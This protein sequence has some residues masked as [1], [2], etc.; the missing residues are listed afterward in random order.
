MA[1]HGVGLSL[2]GIKKTYGQAVALEHI[3]LTVAPGE[4]MTF[5][6]PSGSGK[7]TTL[8]L[9]AG[10]VEPDRGEIEVGGVP[11]VGVPAHKRD[12]GVVFQQ[13]L[14]FPHMKVDANIAFPLRR[15]GVTKR[16]AMRR[17]NEILDVVGLAGM[18]G[19]YPRQ[20]SGG[21]QQ[22]VA[23][24][25]AL[26]FNPKLLLL[27]EPL[28]ALD[29]RLRETLQL[30]IRRIHREIGV[31]FIFVTHDQEEALAMSDRIAVF[32][33]G[34]IEQVGTG[35]ELYQDPR[36]LFV[37]RFLGDSNVIS[38]KV[39]GDNG[40][41]YLSCGDSKVLTPQAAN[42]GE[43]MALVLRPECV[44]LLPDDGSRTTGSNQLSGEVA[45]VTFFGSRRRVEV[46]V[47]TQAF[48]VDESGAKSS[49]KVGEK[50]MV[51]WRVEDAHLVPAETAH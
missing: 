34:L 12:I 22:R 31:T 16:D 17:V 27:D 38:G 35:E 18:A 26:V 51:E 48:I 1:E 5:L 30:E 15:R 29:K 25:R 47:G 19:R 44:R 23:L 43:S 28:G 33:N 50:V 14:L 40:L 24:A 9:I 6:G 41:T 20:L 13:Y 39:Q 4:F 3:D 8:N 49:P 45:D 37:A 36:T 42:L 10:F 21:Q 7:T 2:R 32:N 11:L 46:T